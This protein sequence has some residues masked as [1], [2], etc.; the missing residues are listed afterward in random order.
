MFNAPQ[1]SALLG[2]AV[3]TAGI[4]A[5]PLQIDFGADAGTQAGWEGLGGTADGSSQSGTFSG[6]TDLAIGDIDVALTGLEFNRRHNNGNSNVDFPGTDL[7]AMYGDMLFRND[8]GATVNVTISGLQAGT[9]SITVHS[10]IDTSAPGKFD[11]NVQDA[12]SPAFGQ[13]VEDDVDQGT[14]NAST[15][16]PNVITFEVVSNGTDDIILQMVQGTVTTSG[17]TTGGWFGYSGLEIEVVP[18]P[19]SLALLGLGALMIA[20]RRRG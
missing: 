19:S 11:L 20:G 15:F 5:A 16:S 2:I 12:N 8:D 4:H 3:L 10:L 17:G 14:G 7:D 18:E 1:L 6:Y 9:Y 13:S